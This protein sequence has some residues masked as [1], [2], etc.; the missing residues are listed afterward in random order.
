LEKYKTDHKLAI[1]VGDIVDSIYL[2]KRSS[3][4]YVVCRIY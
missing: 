4:R 2:N 1:I 3:A